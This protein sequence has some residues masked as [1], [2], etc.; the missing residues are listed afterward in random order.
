M[1]DDWTPV[2][3]GCPPPELVYAAGTGVLTPALESRVA[4]HVSSCAVC[5]ALIASLDDPSVGAITKEE[6][7]R[8]RHRLDGE[9]GRITSIRPAHRFRWAAAAALVVVGGAAAGTL[10]VWQRSWSESAEAPALP[11]AVQQSVPGPSGAISGTVSTV[12]GDLLAGVTVAQY[13]SSQYTDALQVLTRVG[14]ATTTDPAGRY[15]IRLAPARG[16]ILRASKPGFFSGGR[17]PPSG[18]EA[19]QEFRLRPW[20]ITPLGGTIIDILQPTELGCGE[21]CQQFAFSIPANE[22]L[23]VSLNTPVRA[24]MDLWIETPTGELYSPRDE[25]PLRVRI[26]ARMPG[27]YQITVISFTAEKRPFQLTI[28]VR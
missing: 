14:P 26:P 16:R 24:S 13:V 9:R 15:E 7:D 5:R 11:A 25:A 1:S 4:E 27:V 2:A 3:A 19:R 12:A 18:P 6:T 21:P 17:I 28:E 20:T 22:T 10:V 23:D 8:I